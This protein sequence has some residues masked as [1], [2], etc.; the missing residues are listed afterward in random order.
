MYHSHKLLS[1]LSL[2][3]ASPGFPALLIQAAP[4]QH[5]FSALLLL[6]VRALNSNLDIKP[7]T[8]VATMSPCWSLRGV[9]NASSLSFHTG[10]PNGC[11]IGINSCPLT[12]D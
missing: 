6:L 1:L 2:R 3:T 5:D 10:E 12:S 11:D 9:L 7:R 4:L 8:N